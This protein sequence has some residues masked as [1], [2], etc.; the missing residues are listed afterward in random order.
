MFCNDCAD[1]SREHLILLPSTAISAIR[2]GSE[3][4]LCE[5]RWTPVRIGRVTCRFLCP[6]VE[7]LL[8]NPGPMLQ[9]IIDRLLAALAFMGRYG[10]Q[11]FA[12]SIL[13]GLALP[14]FAAAA[15]PL[16]PVTIFLFVA[17]TFMRADWPPIRLVLADPVRLLL[18]IAWFVGAPLGMVGGLLMLVG[19]DMM[20]P[21]LVLGLAVLAAA[22]PVMSGPAVAMMLRLDPALVLAATILTTAI[23]PLIAP[24][25][26]D[27]I[28]GAS[29]PLDRA[30]LMLRLL[31]LIGGAIVVAGLFRWLVGYVRISQHGS[32]FDG[33]GVLMYFL[34]A[35]AAMDGVTA[36]ALAMPAK[37]TLFLGVACGLAFV[38][39][40]LAY[41]LL[42]PFMSGPER[43][44][45]GYGTAQRNM[46][47]L[48][49]A[50]GPSVPPSTFLFFALAQFP[51]YLMPQIIKPLAKR[52]AAR[53][54]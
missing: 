35:I 43:F 2:S 49:A 41:V 40:V 18:A 6:T 44:T 33:F 31:W 32:S 51:I 47:L 23:S 21:G 14:Q 19:R 45:L 22:P 1:L 10:T 3:G 28:A 46:G 27:L 12:L 54:G 53:V 34:F 8:S 26:V 15:R 36:A 9:S 52:F 20:E 42:S 50:L 7:R 39:F 29:V 5:Q 4:R 37:V 38:G 48:I 11:G 17:M 13:M 24:P 30:V 16:L 25:L